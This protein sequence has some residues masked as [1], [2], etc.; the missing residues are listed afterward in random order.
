MR[1]RSQFGGREMR[2]ARKLWGKGPWQ[3]EPDAANFIYGGYRCRAQRANLGNWCGYV[4]VPAGHPW[5]GKKRH[6]LESSVEVHGGV[7]FAED[8]VI[9]FDCAHWDDEIPFGAGL[10]KGLA[11]LLRGTR[12]R[13]RRAARRIAFMRYSEYRTLP[14][15]IDEIK[16][17]AEQAREATE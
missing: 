4:Q 6:E 15:V 12:G 7:T 16:R 1:Y 17:L 10:S 14:Y 5:L 9:G 11:G 13:L 3:H 2:R 8:G